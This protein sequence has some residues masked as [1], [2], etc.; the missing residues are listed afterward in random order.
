MQTQ[1]RFKKF[2]VSSKSGAKENDLLLFDKKMSVVDLFKD[3]D[4]ALSTQNEIN[5]KEC[6]CKI[7]TLIHNAIGEF[8]A[9]MTSPDTRR[10]SIYLELKLDAYVEQL[11][12]QVEA[13]NDEACKEKGINLREIY[14]IV[15]I[16]LVII[17]DLAFEKNKDIIKNIKSYLDTPIDKI[18]K[19]K[20]QIT[21][22]IS[23][24]VADE[25]YSTVKNI[26]PIHSNSGAIGF[27]TILYAYYN[28]YLPVGF[29][30][31]PHSVHGGFFDG[32]AFSTMQHDYGHALFRGL[33]IINPYPE[34]FKIYMNTYLD[35][36]SKAEQQQLSCDDLKKGI[37]V[38]FFLLHERGFPLDKSYEENLS[39]IK[40][41][42]DELAPNESN[43]RPVFLDAR[44]RFTIN[45]ILIEVIDF[46]KP[47]NSLGYE[48]PYPDE[49]KS[50]LENIR[51]IVP[52]LR[53]A[54]YSLIETFDKH[55]P[56][57]LSKNEKLNRQ[58]LN[59]GIYK[60][61][62]T[63]WSNNSGKNNIKNEQK[64]SL[65]GNHRSIL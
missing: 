18:D 52:P 56:T 5:T 25:N 22:D 51:A 48:I 46:I 49:K 57:A 41:T 33:A 6:A 58:D 34:K 44:Y 30:I 63:L 14:E 53:N 50:K 27:N 19:F 12:Q 35:I 16:K 36:I 21:L 54:F 7:R 28:G 43:I 31:N 60:S 4:N 23:T 26:L 40:E 42:I 24:P 65:S 29:G 1:S 3:Y 47:L 9:A 20:R 39:T 15:L 32:S 11:R 8:E 62:L 38:L 37:L 59:P 55:C 10:N 61:E 2:Q 17:R 64:I 45:D 13:L